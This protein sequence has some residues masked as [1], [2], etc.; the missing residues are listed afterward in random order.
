MI[1]DAIVERFVQLC[2]ERSISY[3][4]L[5]RLA[6][7]SPSTVY[8]MLQPD[9]RDVSAITVKKLCDGLELCIVEFY[10]CDIFRNLPPE[11]E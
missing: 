4:H 10:D 3:T 11:I 5:A 1:K 2:K 8:S 7:V 9:R 6:G